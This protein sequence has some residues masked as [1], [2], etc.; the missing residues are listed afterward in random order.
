M[1]TLYFN[2]G[3]DNQY[4]VTCPDAYHFMFSPSTLKVELIGIDYTLGN[5]EVTITYNTMT[6]SRNCIAGVAVFDLMPIFESFFA[7]STFNL[8]DT[9]AEND[10]F[11]VPSFNITIAFGLDTHDIPFSLRWGALQFDEALS[12]TDFKFPFWTGKPLILNSCQKHDQTLINGANLDSGVK[13]R[14][15]RSPITLADF[16]YQ[17]KLVGASVQTITF[18]LYPN[19]PN[20]H[21]LRWIDN[22]GQVWQFMFWPNRLVSQTTAIKSRGE[23]KNYPLSLSDGQSGVSRNKGKDKQRTLQCFASVDIEI[24]PIIESIASSPLVWI[25]RNSQ[26]IRVDVSDMTINTASTWMEDIEFVVELP[27]DF[28]Q[29]I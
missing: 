12:A 10:P 26:F 23:I 21:Y 5:E 2:E 19:I 24:A 14:P 9:T 22:H 6:F 27:K 11:Y 17:T 4:R 20:G 28:V 25:Y 7:T 29:R 15:V 1:R 18:E 16:T 13:T 8:N 3:A